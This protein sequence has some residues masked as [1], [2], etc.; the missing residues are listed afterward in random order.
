MAI[1]NETDLV[2]FLFG[3]GRGVF[4]RADADAIAAVHVKDAVMGVGCRALVVG[5]MRVVEMVPVAIGVDEDEGVLPVSKSF[6]LFLHFCFESHGNVIGR[7]GESK[8]GRSAWLR[9]RPAPFRTT[10]ARP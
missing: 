4:R 3:K 9:G 2:P 7:F 8:L 6:G 1:V 5:K 10:S